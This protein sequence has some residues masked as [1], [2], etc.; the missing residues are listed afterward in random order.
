MLFEWALFPISLLYL[1]GERNPEYSDKKKRPQKD[2]ARNQLSASQ[3]RGLMKN[4]TCLHP[5]LG[6]PAPRM[7]RKKISVI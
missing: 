7:V 6:L 5:D 2:T 4:Y 3:E 1:E